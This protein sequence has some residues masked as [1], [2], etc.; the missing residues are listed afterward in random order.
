MAGAEGGK[1]GGN[2]CFPCLSI[3][4]FSLVGHSSPNRLLRVTTLFEAE[5][6]HTYVTSNKIPCRFKINED[7]KVINKKRNTN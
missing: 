5:L 6:G 4:A 1:G 7:T 2:H 3:P